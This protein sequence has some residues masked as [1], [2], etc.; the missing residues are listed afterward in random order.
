MQ[1]FG[2]TLVAGCHYF[3]I[4][5][6]KSVSTC[7]AFLVVLGVVVCCALGTYLVG[8]VSEVVL[9]PAGAYCFYKF[10]SP[11]VVYW[12]TPGM[13]T[14]LVC[15]T[16]FYIGIFRFVIQSHRK[17]AP[18]VTP[19]PSTFSRSSAPPPDRPA[20]AQKS[21]AHAKRLEFARRTSIY[22]LLFALG[23][24]VAVFACFY[25]LK[26]GAL[27]EGLD[28]A[29]A[30]CGSLHTLAVPLVYGHHTWQFRDWLFMNGCCSDATRVARRKGN[31]WHVEPRTRTVY[32]EPKAGDLVIVVHTVAVDGSPIQGSPD[33]SSGITWVRS[34]LIE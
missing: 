4:V 20:S 22:V 29:L 10:S 18:L 34:E 33:P 31:R 9:M 7:S 23:W 19:T 26:T 24:G 5:R 28:I 13:L 2:V 21:T 15:V 17:V 8:T 32:V 27:P 11:L 14:A 1:F 12:F 25:T 6:R 16:V 30:V 3:S